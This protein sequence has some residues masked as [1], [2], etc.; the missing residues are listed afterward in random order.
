MSYSFAASYGASAAPVESSSTAPKAA[1]QTQGAAPHGFDAAGGFLGIW[2]QAP[3]GPTPCLP[4]TDADTMRRHK[5][6]MSA[7]GETMCSPDIDA[8]QNMILAKRL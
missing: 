2:A 5:C 3:V 8:G 4:K 7:S 6:F 1:G